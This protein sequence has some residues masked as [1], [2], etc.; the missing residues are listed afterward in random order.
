MLHGTPLRVAAV[1]LFLFLGAC[2]GDDSPTEPPGN[3]VGPAGGTFSFADGKVT[4]VFPSGALTEEIAV[5]V[6]PTASFP[7]NAR[8]V[9]GTVYSFGPPGIEFSIPVQLKMKYDPTDLP[10]GVGESELRLHEVAGSD[11]DELTGGTVNSGA[12]EVS[13][14]IRGFSVLGILGTAVASVTVSPDSSLIGLGMTVQL[15][16]AVRDSRSNTLVGRAVSWTSSDEQAARVD[17]N[18][19]VTG[20]APGST[21]I[22]AAS[23][24]IVDSARVIVISAVG[25]IVITSGPANPRQGDLVTYTAEARDSQGGVIEEVTITFSVEPL[26][27]GLSFADGRFVGYTPGA[28]TV[29]ASGI[30]LADTL[31]I[32]IGSRGVAGGAFNMVGRGVESVRWTSDLWVHG[33]Y[34]YLGTWNCRTQCGNRLFVWD[35]SNPA[36]P[37]LTDSVSV[38]ATTVNDVKVRADGAIAVISREGGGSG[39]TILDLSVPASPTILATFGAGALAAGVHNVW[40][41]G[42]HI[43]AVTDGGNAATG[44][45]RVIDI[46]T[47]ASPSIVASFYGG[48]SFLHDVYVR[49]GLAFL[50][51][52]NAGLIILDVGNGMAGGSP[53]A[54]SEVSRLLTAGGQTHNA[55]YWPAGGYVFVGEEDFGT[56]GIMHVV[57]VSDMRNPVEVA[58]YRVSGGTTPHN[59]WLDEARSIIYLGWY[60]NGVR[61][62]DVSGELLGELEKQGRDIANSVYDG[63]GGCVAAGTCTWAPQLH[64]GRIFL[65]DLNSGLWV[66]EPTF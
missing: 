41:E 24:G 23:E 16:A 56:P 57:D 51:H 18:G 45:M 3:S 35:I 14:S 54:P 9:N 1:G 65:S 4:L 32:T 37:L 22:S 61:A 58:T 40:I 66:L 10:A 34:A 49:D 7:N 59:F 2:G 46:S 12:R 36:M 31:P 29:I 43:Y 50:S 55:W 21:Y 27:A 30:G 64:N 6:E 33:D 17:A 38:T 39:I 20:V 26:S 8:V 44:G 28:A 11:W 15:N 52:W 48:S 5:S 42:D 25:A 47:P 19:L 60:E 13:V 53:N 62:L 63:A